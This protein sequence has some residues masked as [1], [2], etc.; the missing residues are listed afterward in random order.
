VEG[1]PVRRKVDHVV[2]VDERHH[3]AGD[4]HLDVVARVVP[5]PEGAPCPQQLFKM[6]G[7]YW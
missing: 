2:A 4:V 6:T 3:L 5:R 1:L 7:L